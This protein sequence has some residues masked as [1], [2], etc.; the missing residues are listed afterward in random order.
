VAGTGSSDFGCLF[1]RLNCSYCMFNINLSI[2]Y[3]LIIKLIIQFEANL[4]DKPIKPKG[5]CWFLG[6]TYK[7]LNFSPELET[8]GS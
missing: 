1:P 5:M 6:T 2:K 8:S 3:R 7:R 4:R